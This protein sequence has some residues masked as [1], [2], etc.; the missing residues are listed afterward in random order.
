M[1]DTQESVRND[2]IIF[3]GLSHFSVKLTQVN[4]RGLPH[5][6]II[7]AGARQDPCRTTDGAATASR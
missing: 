3:P 6:V 1:F 4:G 2:L 7:V 5:I